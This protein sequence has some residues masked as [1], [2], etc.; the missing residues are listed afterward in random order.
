MCPNNYRCAIP[1]CESVNNVNNVMFNPDWLKY[2]V[3]FHE[4]DR[5]DSCHRF[6]MAHTESVGGNSCRVDSFNRSAISHCGNGPKI[7]RTDEVSIVTKVPNSL[8]LNHLRLYSLVLT[9]NQ[10]F[11]FN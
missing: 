8:R 1:E 9:S 10:Y 5:P 11:I 3:P 7:F 4:N 6:E 2:S